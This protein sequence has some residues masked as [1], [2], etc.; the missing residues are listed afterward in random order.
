MSAATKSN[1]FSETFQRGGSFSIQKF[2]LQ[3]LDLYKGLEKGFLKKMQYDYSKL[4]GGHR[5][6]G[7]FPK[8][9]PFWLAPP[10]P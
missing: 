3:I 8:I 9:H 1:E 4:R 5:P 2:I 7:I 10:V 6:C